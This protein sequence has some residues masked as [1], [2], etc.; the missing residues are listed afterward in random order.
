[1]NIPE[2]L[3]ANGL[4]QAEFARQLG[5]SPGLVWQWLNGETKVTA[6]RAVQIEAAT[7]GQVTREEIRPD[8]YC[9]DAAPC[10]AQPEARA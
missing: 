3:E 7:G 10:A 1:M 8:L 2:Y 9:R 5:V 6:E 4:Q